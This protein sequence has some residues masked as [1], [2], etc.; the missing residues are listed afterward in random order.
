VKPQF[1]AGPRDAPKGVVRDPAVRASAVARVRD[2]A[3]SIGLVVL[4][5]V[6]SSLTGP[7][8]NRETFLHLRRPPEA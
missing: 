6:E 3:A 5:E 8:G 7:A 4:G 2:H 1:E